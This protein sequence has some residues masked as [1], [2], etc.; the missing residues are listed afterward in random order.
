MEAMQIPE[1]Q[2]KHKKN[3]GTL[4]GNPVFEVYLVGGL[5]LLAVVD[6]KLRKTDIIATG[7]HRALSRHIAKMKAPDIIFTELNKGE[8]IPVEH[9]SWCLEKYIELTEK[10]NKMLGN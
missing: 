3:V 1:N 2:I 8:E 9:F 6:A 5:H 7:K 4:K 10:L